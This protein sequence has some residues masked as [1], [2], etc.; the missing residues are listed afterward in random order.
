MY[1]KIKENK[2]LPE[3]E[4]EHTAMLTAVAAVK[5]GDLSN[6]ARKDYVFDITDTSN[7]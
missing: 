1:E 4:A 2:D 6:E 7:W 3:E 5:Y